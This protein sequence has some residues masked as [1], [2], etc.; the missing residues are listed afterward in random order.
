MANNDRREPNPPVNPDRDQELND[1]RRDRNFIKS[2]GREISKSVG[3]GGKKVKE[4]PLKAAGGFKDALLSQVPFL[5]QGADF[6]KRVTEG[7]ESMTMEEKEVGDDIVKQNKEETTSRKS[8][9]GVFTRM[10]KGIGSLATKTDHQTEILATLLEV[11]DQEQ[12]KMIR[13]QQK[14]FNEMSELVDETKSANFSRY[15]Q[16]AESSKKFDK[17]INS[18]DGLETGGG[19]GD[20]DKEKGAGGIFGMLK[21][22]KGGKI[23]GG[24]SRFIGFISTFGKLALR[25]GGITTAILAIFDFVKGFMN[26]GEILDKVNPDILDKIA[27]GIG[28][29]IGDLAGMVDKVLNFFGIDLFDSKDIDKKVAVF[30]TDFLHNAK[31]ILDDI[32]S[33]IADGLLSIKDF[34]ARPFE[35]IKKIGHWLV[36]KFKDIAS[37]FGVDIG[38]DDEQKKPENKPVKSDKELTEAQ[39]K[40]VE[41]TR[42]VLF[43]R[44]KTKPD[45]IK[46]MINNLKSRDVDNEEISNILKKAGIKN[47]A[48]VM[49]DVKDQNEKLKKETLEKVQNGAFNL[50]AL[51]NNN[52]NNSSMQNVTGVNV[53]DDE[54]IR[55]T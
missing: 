42:V 54:F 11:W 12:G 22:F 34:F 24:I 53:R 10:E 27:A 46:K 36:E 16:D 20:S 52:V 26:A 51:T 37:L 13:E 7:I 29:V 15:E 33:K 48:K 47:P 9:K 31:D 43:E 21:K 41:K 39:K 50:N 17:L 45:E 19:E 35:S 4:T 38:M 18:V 25:Y 6:I 3:E 1:R 23:F 8:E 40:Q 32:A 49:Q 14:I 5:S 28:N 44:A 2:L 55:G 30:V